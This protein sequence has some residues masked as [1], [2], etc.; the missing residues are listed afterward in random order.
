MSGEISQELC[1]VVYRICMELIDE[2]EKYNLPP[3]QEAAKQAINEFGITAGAVE[4]VQQ[5]S[6]VSYLQ[7]SVISPG[8]APY[9]IDVKYDN[10]DEKYKPAADEVIATP[11]KNKRH[12][13]RGKQ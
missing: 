5:T 11:H 12:K 1:Q 9:K 13:S 7:Q 4:P 10:F 3:I 2:H 8:M 6:Y